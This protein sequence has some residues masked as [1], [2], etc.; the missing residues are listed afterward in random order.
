MAKYPEDQKTVIVLQINAN[1][2]KTLFDYWFHTQTLKNTCDEL[3][4]VW[5]GPPT[6]HTPR[7]NQEPND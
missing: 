1:T 2:H 4:T 6:D 7:C 5:T 3:H